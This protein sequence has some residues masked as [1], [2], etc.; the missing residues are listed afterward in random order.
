MATITIIDDSDTEQP[1]GYN[2]DVGSTDHVNI[3]CP[4]EGEQSAAGN[5]YVEVTIYN[6]AGEI[7]YG[8]ATE[9]WAIDPDAHPHDYMVDGQTNTTAEMRQLDKYLDM[10][11]EDHELVA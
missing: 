4:C 11:P 6:S 8:P 9:A 10:L 2:I 7:K 5:T 3:H 1:V